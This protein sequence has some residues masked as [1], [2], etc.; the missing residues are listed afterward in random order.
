MAACQP[1]NHQLNAPNPTVGASLLAKAACQPTNHQLN[2]L[3]PTVGVSLLAMAAC[4][5]TNHQLNALNPTV[6]EP[7]R[8]DGLPANQS[9]AG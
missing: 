7:A 1:T 3:N 5:P 9:L 2:A 6:C 8:D 4:Q